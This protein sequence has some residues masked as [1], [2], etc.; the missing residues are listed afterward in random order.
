VS[1]I[2]GGKSLNTNPMDVKNTGLK[3]Q[4]TANFDRDAQV[5][6]D[7][8]RRATDMKIKSQTKR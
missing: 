2:I 7:F 3:N 1:E 5:A 6:A 8:L 4:A